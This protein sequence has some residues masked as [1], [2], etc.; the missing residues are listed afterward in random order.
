MYVKELEEK[1]ML[2][3]GEKVRGLIQETFEGDVQFALFLF[4]EGEMHTVARLMSDGR[5]DQVVILMRE[6]LRA[7]AAAYGTMLS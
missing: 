4:D 1:A 6:Y 7:S 5:P 3:F 2:E